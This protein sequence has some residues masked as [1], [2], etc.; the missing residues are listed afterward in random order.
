[1]TLEWTSFGFIHAKRLS[2]LWI[3]GKTRCRLCLNGGILC[4]NISIFAVVAIKFDVMIRVSLVT[5]DFIW[6]SR[7]GLSFVPWRSS[8]TRHLL[9]TGNIEKVVSIGPCRWKRFY[10]CK[11]KSNENQ[12]VIW[13]SRLI[14]ATWLHLTYLCFSIIIINSGLRNGC[15]YCFN[16]TVGKSD[17]FCSIRKNLFL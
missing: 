17:N 8:S 1:M 7:V 9:A 12:I 14:D 4:S 2:L 10:L 15:I 13:C 3:P 16:I 11:Y 5:Y 6:I